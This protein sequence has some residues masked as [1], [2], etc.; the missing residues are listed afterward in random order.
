LAAAIVPN[1]EQTDAK[2]EVDGHAQGIEP[3][4][5]VRHR[6]RDDDL[7]GQCQTAALK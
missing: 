2:V 7:V 4:A 6:T 1:V 5:K 3:R